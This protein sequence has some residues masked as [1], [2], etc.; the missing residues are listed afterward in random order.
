[1]STEI[2]I[3]AADAPARYLRSR[4]RE[5][6]LLVL[7][8]IALTVAL[9]LPAFFVEVFNSD[10]TFLATQAEVIQA[11]GDLY[12]EA[13]DRK[14]PLV[15]YLY[16]ATFE[17]FDTNELWTV[18]VVAMG[19]A[20][21]TAI[22]LALEARRRY[23]PRAA[24]IAG[25]L[26]A[27]AL[28]AAAPQDGQAANFEI[29]MLPSMTAAILLAR[30]GHGAAAGLAVALATL[31]KQ[32]G[33]ITLLPVLYLIARAR[34]RRGI[35][36]T[37][38]GF[39]VPLV[40][41]ALLL[42]PGQVIYWTV[43]GNG[44]Y[45]GVKTIS[46]YVVLSFLLMTLAWIGCNL[47]MVVQLPKAWTNRKKISLDG[48]NDLDLWLWVASAMISIL[49]GLRFFG[50][51]YLQLIPP[52][53]LLATGALSRS[54]KRVAT[55]TIVATGILA[56]IISTAGYFFLPFGSEP[57]YQAVS[58]YLTAHSSA[59]DRLL[60]WGS[61][62]EIYY[63]SGVQ[64]ATRFVTTNT[65]LAGNHPG[66]PGSEAAPEDSDPEVW[67]LFFK[68]MADHPPR[69]IVDTATASIRS[70]EWT[71]LSRF[72]RLSELI[73]EKYRIV[74]VIDKFTVYQIKKS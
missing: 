72:S 49:I 36:E 41:M 23:G 39:G 65:F 60:V 52:V 44:S 27:F 4:K 67:D 11:G 53:V 51:Y 32:T 6:F 25:L 26:C 50:H 71:P 5:L 14:P 45:V 3:T 35:A 16:A 66:R 33:A 7:A 40:L 57:K 46:T 64:P 1:M 9:R 34:G 38:G 70:A 68:D 42:G 74:T 24:W 21:L 43:I 20:A 56:L 18:R 10:E 58:R 62:P 63:E 69:F 31:A 15:P 29:F 47:P 13:T 30:R 8:V 48:N 37:L 17:I 19:A 22:L 28:V 59:N 61:V 73:K 2:S 55:I 12:K 54:S